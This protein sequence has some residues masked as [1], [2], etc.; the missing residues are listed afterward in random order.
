MSQILY[1]ITGSKSYWTK[2][3]RLAVIKRGLIP[4]IIFLFASCQKVIDLNVFDST[5]Q[6]VVEAS[7]S[8]EPGPYIVKLTKTINLSDLTT[9]PPVKGAEVEIADSTGTH[10]TLTEASNGYYITKYTEG[11]PGHKYILTVNTEGK[12]YRAVSEMPVPVE[13][14]AVGITRESDGA[15]GPADNSGVQ[16]YYYRISY[17]IK[18]PAEYTNYYRLVVIHKNVE[19]SSRRVFD[20]QFHNGKL[21]VNDFILR[22]T[23]QYTAGDTVEIDLQNIDRNIYNFFRTLREGA[24]SLGIL[25][26]SP[27]NPLSNIT[28]NGLGYFSA[29]SV[30][31][32]FVTLPQA[33]TKAFRKAP[34]DF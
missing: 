6:L 23:V 19:I 14:F 11:K 30:V 12:T 24:G 29:Y 15:S 31:R 33:T 10:E 28:N 16:G 3:C 26:A 4:L 34:V 17:E 21:I 8:D 27:S 13:D 20:D 5:P 22:D 18:D 2:A 7:V 32:R 1:Y 9:I 25:S